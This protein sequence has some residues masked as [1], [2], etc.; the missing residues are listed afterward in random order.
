MPTAYNGRQLPLAP[1][2][3]GKPTWVANLGLSYDFTG[4]DSTA[5]N[6]VPWVY[7][8]GTKPTLAKTGTVTTPTFAGEPGALLGAGASYAYTSTT[9]YGL[10]VGTGDFTIGV[11]FS[12]GSALPSSAKSATVK[13]GTS[14]TDQINVVLQ[15]DPAGWYLSVA[16][17]PA[18]TV[19]SS[20]GAVIYGI[21]KTIIAWVRR[22]AGVTTVW[23]Q[24]ATTAGALVARYAAGAT[25]AG[26]LDSSNATRLQVASVSGVLGENIQGVSWWRE[27]L[28]NATMQA[29]GQDW[30]LMNTNGV[31][32]S[33]I[34]ITSPASGASIAQTATISGT[35]TSTAPT[36]VQ[37]QHGAGAWV[38]GTGLTATGGTWSASFVLPVNSAAALR[39]RYGNDTTVVSADV[40]NITVIAK[41]IG[42]TYPAAGSPTPTDVCPYRIF[43]RKFDGSG[44]SVQVTGTYAGGTPA[45]IQWRWNGGSWATLVSS[46]AGGTFSASVSLSGVGMGDLEVRWSDDTTVSAACSSVGVGDVYF[47][48]GQSNNVGGASAAYVAPVAPGSNPT[49]KHTELDKAGVWRENVETSTTPMSSITGAQYT[50]WQTGSASGSYAGRLATTLMAS[51]GV[52]VAVIPCAVGSTSL[53]GWGV[54]TPYNNTSFLYGAMATRAGQVGDHRGVIWWQG[55]FEA[56]TSQTQAAHEAGLNALINDWFSRFGKK[57]FLVNLC[58]TGNGSN[59]ATIRAAIA[60]VAATNANVWGLADMNVPSAAFTTSIHYGATTT[61]IDTVAARMYSGMLSASLYSIPASISGAG[62]VASASAVGTP[63]VDGFVAAAISGAGAISSGSAFGTPNVGALWAIS[64]A[65]A[66]GSGAAVGAPTVTASSGGGVADLSGAGGIGASAAVGTPRVT[67]PGAVGDEPVTVEE[68]KS[69]ARIDA[70]DTDLDLYLEGVITSAREQAEQIT[71]RVY[72]RRTFQIKLLD[73]PASGELQHVHEPT[74]CAISY[75]GTDGAWHTL[76]STAYEFAASGPGAEIAPKLDTSWPVLGR[77]AVGERVRIV[78]TAGPSSADEVSEAVKLYIKAHVTGWARNPSAVAAKDFQPSPLLGHLLDSE[79]VY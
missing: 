6:G 29:I 44:V 8:G 65:G 9:D 1:N 59:L 47:L 18:V 74:E 58:A 57:W 69:A 36:S 31:A 4:F 49:W 56:G 62:G 20:S 38:T 60:N 75:W 79:I 43:Q 70:D 5:T 54:P 35:Y 48:G 78:F 22:I 24:D 11:R 33:T 34:A 40:A 71:G 53:S 72:K 63:A 55:E 45:A 39:A 3:S 30:Y 42:F 46:P 68:A 23:T 32:A 52:P 76:D 66:I 61:E 25:N 77:K 15:E 12:T 50:P 21:N 51:H 27:G 73:W 26:S 10:Q 13:I 67:V 64:S 2:T 37:V 19:G 7:T 16:G 14:G 28:D 17:G 41:S